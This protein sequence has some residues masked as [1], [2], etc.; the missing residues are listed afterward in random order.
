MG[1]L[2]VFDLANLV[3]VT[4][5]MVAQADLQAADRRTA[6]EQTGKRQLV[7]ALIVAVGRGID[8]DD[9]PLMIIL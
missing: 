2:V 4:R 8:T 1:A 5:I 7:V 6:E 3:I 9:T